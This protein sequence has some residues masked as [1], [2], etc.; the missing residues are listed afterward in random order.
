MENYK[1]NVN[2]KD[3]NQ[4]ESL[5]NENADELKWKTVTSKK[6]GKM[7]QVNPS[8]PTKPSKRKREDK[9]NETPL[10]KEPKRMNWAALYNHKILT[11]LRDG[12]FML[13]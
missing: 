2:K 1:D 13:R 3:S 6:K 10:Q 11:K 9:S 7:G 12:F 8:E 4:T 5:E